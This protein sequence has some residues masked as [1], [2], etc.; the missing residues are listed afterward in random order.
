MA[1]TYIHGDQTV[2]VPDYWTEGEAWLRRQIFQWLR[3][4]RPTG[5]RQFAWEVGAEYYNLGNGLVYIDFN[6]YR[7]QCFVKAHFYT[8]LGLLV[9]QMTDALEDPAFKPP[10]DEKPLQKEQ[11][12]RPQPPALEG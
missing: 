11:L 10:D 6:E 12:Q 9:D 7:Q 1:T 5:F 4:G 2:K 8:W 3:A